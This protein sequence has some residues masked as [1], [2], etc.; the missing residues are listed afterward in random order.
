MVRIASAL[1]L[2]LLLAG[3]EVYC[4]VA[5]VSALVVPLP[6]AVLRTLWD[7]LAGGYLLPHI[8]VTTAEMAMGLAAGCTIGF[9][10]GVLL[11]EVPVLR[12]LFYPYILA[13]Q[14]VPKLALG[15][16]FIVW[17]GFG[18]TSTVV[19][20]ALICFFPL[21]ENTMTGLQQVDPNKRELFR[22]LRAT[23]LQTLLRL[24]IP[25]GLPVILAGL[26][27]AVVLALVGAVVGEFIGG[28]QGLGASIIAAQGMMDSAMMFALF[29]VITVLGMIVYQAA[30][31]LE[32]WLL[33][34][35]WKG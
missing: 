29:I 22:M 27:V 21:L 15:P 1:L 20:T 24:K 5:G 26:R 10:A 30:A 32:R 28:R 9:L 17:F 25:S 31:G 19:I 34:R 6:S 11:A 3:W 8:W 2:V 7:G 4:R 33:R 35:P 13:S 12:R 18:M 23:R 16:L 14:V